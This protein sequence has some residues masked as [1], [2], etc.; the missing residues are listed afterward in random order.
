MSVS[1][2]LK[3]WNT[4][5]TQQ[6]LV[7]IATAFG[8][9]DVNRTKIASVKMA[10]VFGDVLNMVALTEKIKDWHLDGLQVICNAFS[11]DGS[12]ITG[13]DLTF[14][15]GTSSYDVFVDAFAGYKDKDPITTITMCIADLRNTPH[16]IF[17]HSW[18]IF[19]KEVT[20]YATDACLRLFNWLMILFRLQI[21]MLIKDGCYTLGIEN[22][23]GIY[24]NS[25]KLIATSCRRSAEMLHANTKTSA[26]QLW[27]NTIIQNC[28]SI[29]KFF[30]GRYSFK[31]CKDLASVY[32]LIMETVEI[33]CVVIALWDTKPSTNHEL[34]FAKLKKD[35]N[36]AT[37]KY[38]SALDKLRVAQK[39]LSN[40]QTEVTK[41]KKLLDDAN[42][43]L[44]NA[45]N[46]DKAE[47]P[48]KKPS[49]KPSEKPAKK[50]E[51][52][53]KSFE[54][55][56]IVFT[57]FRDDDLKQRLIKAGNRVTTSISGKTTLVVAKD[58]NDK[59]AKL[60][61]ARSRGIKIISIEKLKAS[62]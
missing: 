56:V 48:S 35:V 22:V 53:V 18:E 21:D 6:E 57:G 49:K 13:Y 41:T 36:A 12:K 15:D 30:N 44:E 59:G 50:S 27:Y 19:D 61:D 23:S 45:E 47:K 55:E 54:N 1:L 24:F 17:Y 10:N 14:H 40:A 2:L 4:K 51:K 37:Q 28:N 9:N 3:D 60:E 58:V 32:K 33:L 62:F 34:K 5:A 42:M 39:D 20:K 46:A 11:F 38:N 52:A 29:D 16:G 8:V 31:S 43:L 7:A 26:A 25:F